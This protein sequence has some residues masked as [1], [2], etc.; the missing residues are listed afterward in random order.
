MSTLVSAESRELRRLGCNH[1][2]A[3]ERIRGTKTHA[4]I[5]CGKSGIPR[6]WGRTQLQVK[7]LARYAEKYAAKAPPYLLR[8]MNTSKGESPSPP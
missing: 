7:V 3:S 4:H 5:Q 1:H 6:N 8:T 2:W